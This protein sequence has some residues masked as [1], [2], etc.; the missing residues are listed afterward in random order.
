[1]V[2]VLGVRAE[3]RVADLR[4]RPQLVADAA[5]GSVE[6]RRAGGHAGEQDGKEQ[7][8]ERGTESGRHR[9]F[10][11]SGGCGVLRGDYEKPTI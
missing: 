9:G 7:A 3:H 1:M 10:T 2:L 4:G 5:V 11:S 8:E 6:L